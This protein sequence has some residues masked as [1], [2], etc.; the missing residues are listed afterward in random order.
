MQQS[1][2]MSL[3]R[4]VEEA[5]RL[6]QGEE[7]KINENIS[8]LQEILLSMRKQPRNDCKQDVPK[9]EAEECMPPEEKEEMEL[10]ERL[11]QKAL[12]VRSGSGV[13][14]GPGPAGDGAGN[15]VQNVQTT[16][17]SSTGQALVKAAS[18]PRAGRV[19]SGKLAAA[20]KPSKEV[21]IQLRHRA[22][23]LG[24]GGVLQC[25]AQNRTAVQGKLGPT[26]R[27]GTGRQSASAPARNERHYPQ[28]S[29]PGAQQKATQK[30]LC[31]E[32]SGTAKDTFQ[33]P[34]ED[35]LPVMVGA[36]TGDRSTLMAG[37]GKPSVP[38]S[39]WRTYRTKHSRLWDKVLAEASK[40][41]AEKT[42]FNER[43]HRTFP[44]KLPHGSPVD[45]GAEVDWL[46]Q[47]CGD[48]TLRLQ[49]ELQAA[50]AGRA[51][52]SGV[53]WELEYESSLM[54]AGLEKMVLDL[55][56]RL[57]QLKRDT[58]TWDRWGCRDCCP[59]RRRGHWRDPAAPDLPHPLTY[60]SQ[61]ELNELEGLRFRVALLKQEMH[62]HQAMRETLTPC[63]IPDFTSDLGCP[64]TGML[65]SLYSLLGEGG[66]QFPALVVDTEPD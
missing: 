36:G 27:P 13:P 26:H 12:R 62:L 21:T 11:L 24:R 30:G 8:Q 1:K 37:D 41:M 32:D 44:S 4:A 55:Q 57:E 48:L 14:R 28:A 10:L 3:L 59:I 22:T 52:G 23:I 43:L 18:K 46:T 64:S 5:L 25:S 6:T 19:N 40:P 38:S 56:G 50:R 39:V 60:T 17:D 61:A 35:P 63:L 58:E 34:C 65:R 42:H 33:P 45:T 7:A 66:A 20:S 16:S 53:C 54:H 2:C 9:A 49:T 15:E 51:P 29:L 31:A 47:L